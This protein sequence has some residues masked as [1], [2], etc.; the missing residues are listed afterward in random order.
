MMM[1]HCGGRQVSFDELASI[2]LPEETD[3][4]K[5][6]AF[7]ELVANTLNISKG[8]LKDYEYK[9]SELALAGN[10]Q[11][12]FGVVKF[13]SQE[14]DEMGLAIGIRSSYDKSMSNGFCM[15]ANV[16]VCDNLVLVELLHICVSI[17][18]M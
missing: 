2:P 12:M 13:E 5:P 18:R 8:L 7:G 14:S 4:Y 6:V 1:L 17:Q 11:R 3:T 9:S 10:D 16:F 15:G